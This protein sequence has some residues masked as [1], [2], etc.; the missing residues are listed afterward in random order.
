[1]DNV[2]EKKVLLD[3][4]VAAGVDETIA[5][6]P[7]NRFAAAM[8]A[9]VAAPET[10]PASNDSAVHEAQT[11]F[12]PPGGTAP[13]A[14]RP[15]PKPPQLQ[16]RDAAVQ[17]A[18]EVAAGCATL[19]ELRA[20]FEAFDGCPLKETAMSFVFADGNPDARLMIIGEAPG[21]EEDRQGLP[22]VG[23]AGQLLDKMLAAIQL[24]RTQ[25]YITN[26]LPWRPPGNRNPTDAEIAACLPFLE[27][28]IALAKPDLLVF[29]GGTAAKT[30]LRRTEGI[31]RLRGK[32]MAY[33]PASGDPVPARALLHPAYLLR[34]PAQKRE[35]WNDLLDIKL[36]LDAPAESDT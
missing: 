3:W 15:A 27:R 26:I 19:E 4:Y 33:E 34:Q 18:Q 8:A 9:A 25:A 31:M 2:A 28:H 1:M 11:T 14:P 29:V 12:A 30:L 6:E 32:W 36:R 7:V 20:A 10:S 35:T 24:D 22:F 17:T 5:E 23:P 16:S 13:T 21:G